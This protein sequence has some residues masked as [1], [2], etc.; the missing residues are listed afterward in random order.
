MRQL[1]FLLIF[2][3]GLALV[4]FTLENTT[5]TTVRLLPG[6]SFTLP[7]AVLLLLVAGVGAT[8]AWVFAV[9]T[10]VVRQVNN[11]PQLAAQQVRIEELQQDVERY[12]SAMDAQLQ[13]LPAAGQSSAEP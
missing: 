12:R 1:N 11:E 6:S 2:A 13:L 7:L 4:M 9:W 5:P 8:A 3:F 10:G